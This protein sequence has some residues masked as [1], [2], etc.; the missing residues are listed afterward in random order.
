M[1][2]DP[3]DDA[4]HAEPEDRAPYTDDGGRTPPYLSGDEER[5]PPVPYTETGPYD[6]VYGGMTASEFELLSSGRFDELSDP[7]AEPEPVATSEV[8]DRPLRLVHV[9]QSM[10]RAGVE[11]WLRGLA[12]FLD[13]RRIQLVKCIATVPRHYN[14]GVVAEM[15]VPVELGGREEVRRAARE[16]DVLLFW[17]PRE[18]ARWIS[19]CRPPL[20]VFVAHGEGPFTQAIYDGCHPIIDHV[21]AVS[22]R[23]RERLGEPESCSVIPNGVDTA[24]LSRSLPRSE[25][26]RRLGFAPDDF[27]IGFVGRF[28]SEKRPE[29]LIH[30]LASL[31]RQFKGL[32]VGWGL[33]YPRLLELANRLIP[34]RYAFATATRSTGD[35]YQAMDA[36]CLPSE[37]EGFALVI[38]EAMLCG[39]PVIATPV[40][41]VPELVLDR[42]NGLVVD[43]S[44]SSIAAAASQLQRNPDWARGL[45]AE[46]QN[47]ADSVGHARRMARDYEALLLELWA[48]H[49]RHQ[50]P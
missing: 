18:L 31:P 32:F 25:A 27:V 40:G 37:E 9:G 2:T 15:G 48:K 29:A 45:A 50:T 10:V 26:R 8:P 46:A 33:L 5:P 6:V 4:S 21:I 12:R 34:G 3:V 11:Q 16:C 14:P 41:C 22:Q 13:S 17:G 35:Y 24:H 30:A 23:V 19:D 1:L 39:R 38:L 28:S 42:I 36:L 7:L 47:L 44:P 49:A 20:C 43:G